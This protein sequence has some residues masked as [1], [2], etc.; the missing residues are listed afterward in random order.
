ML[1]INFN[2]SSDI[3][4]MIKSNSAMV[5]FSQYKYVK[6]TPKLF[7]NSLA[8]GSLGSCMP[9]SYLLILVLL[10]DSSK[11]IETPR[12]SWDNFKKSLLS[13]S[14]LPNSDFSL[15]S[16]VRLLSIQQSLNSVAI[17]IVT[18]NV[19]ANYFS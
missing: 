11:P 13:R 12:D 19:T 6:G 10:Q 9:D 2:S 14:L 17:K 1:V 5:S 4:S 18:N 7:A 16:S 8:V 15:S 3:E